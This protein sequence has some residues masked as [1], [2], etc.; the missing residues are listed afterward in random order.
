MKGRF[1]RRIFV[2]H[3]LGDL[4]FKEGGDIKRSSGGSKHC[5]HFKWENYN[6]GLYMYGHMHNIGKIRE[7]G[8]PDRFDSPTPQAML[9]VAYY[10]SSSC[11]KGH[12]VLNVLGTRQASADSYPITPRPSD[13]KRHWTGLFLGLIEKKWLR[14]WSACLQVQRLT[15]VI[16]IIQCSHFVIPKL[17]FIE[18]EA[19]S[20]IGKVVLITRYMSIRTI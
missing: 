12:V 5:V 16:F 9:L 18:R 10:T 7:M 20:I 8:C 11:N 2:G 6:W 17:Y 3:F 4:V 1:Q 19:N 13:V 15:G 14:P